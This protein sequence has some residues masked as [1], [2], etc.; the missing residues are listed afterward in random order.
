MLIK[1]KVISLSAEAHL[2]TCFKHFIFFVK[3]FDLIEDSEL[4]PLRDLVNSFLNP[5]K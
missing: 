5:T 1:I 4:E 3:E 2:N